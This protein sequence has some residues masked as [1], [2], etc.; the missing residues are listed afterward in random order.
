[1]NNTLQ[2]IVATQL[3]QALPGLQVFIEVTDQQ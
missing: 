1:M 2:K 3:A